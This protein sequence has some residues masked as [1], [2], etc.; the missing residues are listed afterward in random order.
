MGW[1]RYGQRTAMQDRDGV[2]TV[3]QRSFQFSGPDVFGG[4]P[5]GPYLS[6]SV[7]Q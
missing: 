2:I 7:A 6:M 5:S 3:A 1:G 4:Q